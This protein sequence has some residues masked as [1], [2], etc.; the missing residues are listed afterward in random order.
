M[1]ARQGLQIIDFNL[2]SLWICF[3]SILPAKLKNNIFFYFV[4]CYL[5]SYVI[6]KSES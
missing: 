4:F 6:G 5:S 1:V 3:F 2:Y